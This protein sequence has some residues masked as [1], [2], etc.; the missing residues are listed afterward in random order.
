MRELWRNDKG[1]TAVIPSPLL[2]DGVLYVIKN[3]GIL[4]SFDAATGKLIKTGRVEGAISGYSSSPVAAEGRI[5]LAG[6]DGKVAVLRAGGQWEVIAVNDL[7]EPMF[8]TP[9]LSEGQIY[10]RTGG[11]LYRFG[12][13]AAPPEREVP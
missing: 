3:G 8:A 9:A 2:L 12:S 5:Y 11:A 4:T 13:A 6:E 7:G 1:F 10:L